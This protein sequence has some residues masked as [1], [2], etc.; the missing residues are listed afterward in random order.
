MGAPHDA[1]PFAAA[2]Q[3]DLVAA[4]FV[5]EKPGHADVQ[6]ARELDQGGYGRYELMGFDL[7]QH[8]SFDPGLRGKVLDCVVV[9]LPKLPHLGA[10][11]ERCISA[12]LFLVLPQFLH[13]LSLS[14]RQSYSPLA[15]LEC[16]RCLNNTIF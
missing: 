7:G 9:F 12:L 10:D 2:G 3:G 4:G 13:S 15:F 14:F 8:L 6:Y 5:L 16:R 1:H 11:H